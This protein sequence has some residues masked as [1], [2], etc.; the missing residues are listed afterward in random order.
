[1]VAKSKTWQNARDV[2]QNFKFDTITHKAVIIIPTT[3]KPQ[4]ETTFTLSVYSDYD[5][6]LDKFNPPKIVDVK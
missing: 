1:M 3:V 2:Y 4:Q 6:E 5:I